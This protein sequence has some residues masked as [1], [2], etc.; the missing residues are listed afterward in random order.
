MRVL[1]LQT[2]TD[3]MI[4]IIKISCIFISTLKRIAAI[5]L[6]G[7]LL[8]NWCG[9]RILTSYLENNFNEKLE[10]QLDNNN[11]DESNLVTFK[12]PATHLAYYTNYGSFERVD[13]QIEINGVLYKYVKR[14]IYNDS[15]ELSCIPNNA[16]MNLQKM[17]DNFFKSVNDLQ[18]GTQNKKSGSHSIS[19]SFSLDFFVTNNNMSVNELFSSNLKKT[20]SYQIHLPA[21]FYSLPDQPPEVI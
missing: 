17:K 8:F 3:L 4:F 16:V 7:I 13:G 19:K 2:Q 18:T 1:S 15:V 9:Y 10:A 20:I 14:R 5:L 21:S 12:I 6:L 11:Y